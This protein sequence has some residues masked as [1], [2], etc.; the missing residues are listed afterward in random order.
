MLIWCTCRKNMFTK[1]RKIYMK[2]KKGP[3]ILT[4]SPEKETD[5]GVTYVELQSDTANIIKKL[6]DSIPA[7]YTA[8]CRLYYHISSIG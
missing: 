6:T 1:V 5:K 7:V 4:W 2:Q 8:K 3:G